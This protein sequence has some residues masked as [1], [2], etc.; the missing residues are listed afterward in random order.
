MKIGF[1]IDLL[2]IAHVALMALCFAAP[3]R[4]SRAWFM[5]LLIATTLAGVY[6][7]FR[8]VPAMQRAPFTPTATIMHV[9]EL[10]VAIWFI[11]RVGGYFGPN[12]RA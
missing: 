8:E 7:L 10:V 4:P 2:I 1:S 9:V 3:T 6:F 11:L 12:Q 5:A